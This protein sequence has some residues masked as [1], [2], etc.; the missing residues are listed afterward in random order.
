MNGVPTREARRI[1]EQLCETSFSKS[2]VSKLCKQLDPLVRDWNERPLEGQAFPFLFA[3][4]LQIELERTA[5]S[6]PAFLSNESALG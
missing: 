2:T 3:D 1:T 6:P 5:A 4:A